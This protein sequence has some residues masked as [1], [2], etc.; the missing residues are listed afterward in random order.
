MMSHSAGSDSKES[1]LILHNE[2]SP[3]AYSATGRVTSIHDEPLSST[4][5]DN[6]HQSINDTSASDVENDTSAGD[7]DHAAVVLPAQVASQMSEREIDQRLREQETLKRKLEDRLHQ[8]QNS[9]NLVKG[10]PIN[11]DAAEETSETFNDVT[12]Q[13]LSKEHDGAFTAD[14][15][16]GSKPSAA[17]TKDY[18]WGA[19]G[20]SDQRMFRILAGL[21]LFWFL[22]GVFCLFLPAAI[23][24][25]NEMTI[26]WF[27]WF[28]VLMFFLLWVLLQYCCRSRLNR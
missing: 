20:T 5:N 24:A 21:L 4:S 14:L 26:F 28:M 25:Y 6:P 16:Q 22:V 7:V 11:E 17:T 9:S 1:N 13:S 15:E 18:R 2:N 3:S 27:P 12:E 10:V 19:S 8:L 23:G